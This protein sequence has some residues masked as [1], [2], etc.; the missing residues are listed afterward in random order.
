MGRFQR[1]TPGDNR[2]AGNAVTRRQEGQRWERAAESFLCRQ[3]LKV[4]ERNYQCRVGEIDLIMFEPPSLVFVEVKYR[5]ST[6]Y[7]DGAE[8][9]TRSKQAKISRTAAFFLSRHRR[10]ANVPCR[11]DVISISGVHEQTRTRWIKN[12]FNSQFG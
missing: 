8:N 3:G 11:F 2:L 12:A 4:L 10:L 7:G 6:R 9:V 1:R 5:K